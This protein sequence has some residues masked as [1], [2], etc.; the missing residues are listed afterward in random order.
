M[1]AFYG[2]FKQA[3]EGKCNVPK[4][5]FFDFEGKKK[6]QAWSDVGEDVS[7]EAARARYV[8]LLDDVDPEWRDK[9]GKDGGQGKPKGTSSV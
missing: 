5:G 9:S 1:L 6:W 2:L 7:R 3:R 4:P 8:A